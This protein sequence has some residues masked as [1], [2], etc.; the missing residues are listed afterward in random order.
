MEV[1]LTFILVLV[2]LGT[3]RKY[4][5]TGPNAAIAVGG[6]I[7]LDGLFASPVSGASMNPARS[8]GS[9]LIGGSLHDVWVYVVGPVGGA[10]LAAAC[11]WA[12]KGAPT[13]SQAD[14]ANGAEVG[15]IRNQ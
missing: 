12:L 1:V 9:A 2:I 4:L 7:A 10:L 5:I 13:T 11:T 8:L 14:T 3:A 6:A 15:E